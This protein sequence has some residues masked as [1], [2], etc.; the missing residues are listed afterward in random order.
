MYIVPI[1]CVEFYCCL[2]FFSRRLHFDFALKEK[3]TASS[4]KHRN[5]TEGIKFDSFMT[6][7]LKSLDVSGCK[8]NKDI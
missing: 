6:G 3:V 2:N 7:P 1:T 5:R 8:P 4:G